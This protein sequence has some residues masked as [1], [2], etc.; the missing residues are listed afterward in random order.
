ME[1]TAGTQNILARYQLLE[2]MYSKEIDNGFELVTTYGIA[3]FVDGKEVQAFYHI[4]EQRSKV[5]ELLQILN[6][7][8]VE[9][10]HFE[11]VV[12][13]WVYGL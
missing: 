6:K 4:L 9:P 10:C 13:D 8:R 3:M 12:Y 5:E 2:A 7:E 1:E 11:F